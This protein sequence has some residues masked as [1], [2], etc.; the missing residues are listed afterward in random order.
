MNLFNPE[1]GQLINY[2]AMPLKAHSYCARDTTGTSGQIPM[3]DL[4]GL[5]HWQFSGVDPRERSAGFNHAL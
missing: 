1:I 3:A 4:V 2:L 5:P